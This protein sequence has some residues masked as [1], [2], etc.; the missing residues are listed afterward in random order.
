MVFLVMRESNK[1]CSVFALLRELTRSALLFQG[2]FL[3]RCHGKVGCRLQLLRR[4]HHLAMVRT[5]LRPV[6]LCV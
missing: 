2:R 1:E 6:F 3:S 4:S 5:S